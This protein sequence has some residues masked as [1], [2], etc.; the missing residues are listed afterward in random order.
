MVLAH[1]IRMVAHNIT[2]PVEGMHRAVSRRWIGLAGSRGAAVQRSYDTLLDL[3]YGSVRIGS[4]VLAVALD[5]TVPLG[6]SAAVRIRGVANGLWGDALAI[7][8]HALAL[9]M[10]IRTLN[11]TTVAPERSDEAGL[12]EATG[13]VVVL[14][15][16]LF[17][18]DDVWR[19]Q[20]NGGFVGSLDQQGD[21]TVL[22]VR[23]NSGLN[24]DE[25]GKRLSELLEVVKK[26]WPVPIESL[27]LVGKSMGGLVVMRAH[28]SGLERD[29]TWVGLLSHIVTVAAPHAGTPI[30]GA[31]DLAVRALALSPETL[32]LS[33][34]LDSRSRGVKDMRS[35]GFD[36]VS[37]ASSDPPYPLVRAASSNE[38]RYHFLAVTVTN[39]PGHL[40]AE[41]FGDLVVGISSATSRES[42]IDCDRVVVGGA[43][44]TSM[45]AAPSVINQLLS[46][47]TPATHASGS[48][49]DYARET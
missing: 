45:L 49:S 25:N 6:P 9:E 14:V 20:D 46:W 10:E 8:G 27:S 42:A 28:E 15:H 40:L 37:D 29:H 22:T 11:E 38:C 3:V 7:D 47:V 34:F 30:A 36:P 21:M 18:T 35:G 1:S 12:P 5:H 33:Q 4:T 2:T 16:G 43:T 31:V 41:A 39:D 13:H 19:S 24:V 44:H 23:Y 26:S 48:R 17:E 32:P